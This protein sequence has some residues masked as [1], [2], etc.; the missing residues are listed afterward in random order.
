ML[1]KYLSEDIC[2]IIKQKLTLDYKKYRIWCCTE[3]KWIYFWSEYNLRKIECPNEKSHEIYLGF[4]KITSCIN[5]EGRILK[6]DKT[7]KLTA[8]IIQTDFEIIKF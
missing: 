2:N 5:S 8:D 3:S 1:N 7:N 6:I 4:I